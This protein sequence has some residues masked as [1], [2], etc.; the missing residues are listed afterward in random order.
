M[1]LDSRHRLGYV[2]ST[3]SRPALKPTQPPTC[4]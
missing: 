4:G 2:F 3:A 1:G